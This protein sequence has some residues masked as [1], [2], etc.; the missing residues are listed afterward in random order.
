[1]V[2]LRNLLKLVH[3]TQPKTRMKR[4]RGKKPTT[5]TA[6]Q[7]HWVRARSSH[8]PLLRFSGRVG[9]VFIDLQFLK[10]RVFRKS[11]GALTTLEGRLRLRVHEDVFETAL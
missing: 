9:T 5:S 8:L 10:R 1:M 2:V 6:S 11:G 4:R 3:K 7:E